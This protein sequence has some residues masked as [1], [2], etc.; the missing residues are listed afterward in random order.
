M[1]SCMK[2]FSLQLSQVADCVKPKENT[3][4]HMTYA[5]AI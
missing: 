4:Q 3:D 2:A 5:D 1:R